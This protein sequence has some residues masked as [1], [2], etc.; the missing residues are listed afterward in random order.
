MLRAFIGF[1]FLSSAKLRQ[2]GTQ[3]LYQ[4]ERAKC[5]KKFKAEFREWGHFFQLRRE[6]KLH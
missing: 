6:R 2:V 3:L 4:V 1:S 5:D